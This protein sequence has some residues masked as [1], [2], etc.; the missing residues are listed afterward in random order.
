MVA[1]IKDVAKRADVSVATVSRLLNGT[2][3]VREKTAKRVHKAVRD[4]NFRPNAL[5]RSL[6]TSQTQSIGVVIP[7]MSNPVF[8]DAV[9]GINDEVRSRGYTLMF[10]STDYDKEDEL[11][12]VSNLL[13][14]QVDGLI[15]T[16]A[17]PENSPVLDMLDETGSPYVLIYNQPTA[18]Q[19]PTVTIDN[20]AAGREAANALLHLGHVKTGMV[21]GLFSASDRAIARREGF[22]QCIKQKNYPA[23]LILEVDYIDLDVQDVLADIYSD[24]ATAPTGLFCSND[25]L[26]I[27]VIGALRRLGLK[28][29]QDIS[30]IG[31]DGITVGTHL[32]PTLATVVQPSR[33]MGQTA[34][35]LLLDRLSGKEAPST[36]ILP[37][38]LRLGESAGPV[39]KPSPADLQE[40][41]QLT[42]RRPAS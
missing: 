32:N 27:S 6:S 16:V 19:R 24:P 10:T 33:E 41:F 14:Y 26:A 40:P 39:T 21:S 28:V 7:S 23:P 35:R 4:L 11:R 31:F 37:H 12:A 2:G 42:H 29:P 15:L 30:V 25:L 36:V 3:K 9:A 18:N 13:D 8:A 38:N 20:I 1:T 22:V 34:T 5:G 17:D